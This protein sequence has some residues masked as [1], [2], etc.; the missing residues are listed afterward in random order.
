VQGVCSIHF[1]AC[2]E[3]L[4]AAEDHQHSHVHAFT[5]ENFAEFVYLTEVSRFEDEKDQKKVDWLY[6]DELDPVLQNVFE[7]AIDEL[8]LAICTHCDHGFNLHDLF[9]HK[10]TEYIRRFCADVQIKK[11][12]CIPAVNV[13][14]TAVFNSS[15]Y[16]PDLNSNIQELTAA[17][18]MDLPDFARRRL[19]V[20]N[21]V[22]EVK[23]GDDEIYE[24]LS[25]DLEGHDAT[26][27]WKCAMVKVSI[28]GDGMYDLIKGEDIN[29]KIRESVSK[30][31]NEENFNTLLSN[32]TCVEC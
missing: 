5:K 10:N 26:L 20:D 4:E 24:C 9:L 1:N 25:S 16:V 29:K 31:I 19:A 7:G 30:L 15:L 21:I 17:R 32:G 12:V 14:Y 27:G 22:T 11:K 2:Q 3:A 28:T 8:G 18:I 6:F 13:A 23:L